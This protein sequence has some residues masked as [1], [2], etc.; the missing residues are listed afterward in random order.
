LLKRIEALQAK[1]AEREAASASGGDRK[2]FWGMFKGGGDAATLKEEYEK[3]EKM[4]Q[5]A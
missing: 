4:Y 2:G 3:I 5:V 1:Q